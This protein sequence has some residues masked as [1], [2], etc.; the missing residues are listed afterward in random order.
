[1]KFCENC[2]GDGKIDIDARNFARNSL[3]R[4]FGRHR[5]PDDFFLRG[6]ALSY[7]GPSRYE[8]NF[9]KRQGYGRENKFI[10]RKT[11]P[12]GVDDHR[13]SAAYD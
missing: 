1:M 2:W 9:G 5:S 4:S 7:F 13:A 3:S 10:R 12:V 8:Q 11:G 6:A